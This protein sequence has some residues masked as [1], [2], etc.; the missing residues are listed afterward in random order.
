MDYTQNDLQPNFQILVKL[1][2]LKSSPFWVLSENGR[3]N[4][5]GHIL[6]HMVDVVYPSSPYCFHVQKLGN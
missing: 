4:F 1:F 2:V 6:F 5:P 3:D